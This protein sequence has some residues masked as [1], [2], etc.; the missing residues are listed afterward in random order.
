MPSFGIDN[1]D[2]PQLLEVVLS[3]PSPFSRLFI[4]T[5]TAVFELPLLGPRDDDNL[6]QQRL[7]LL[8]SRVYGNIPFNPNPGITR[9]IASASPSSIHGTDDANELTWAVDRAFADVN[10]QGELILHV[11]AAVQG[12]G[13]L[14]SRFAYQVFVQTSGM[15]IVDSEQNPPNPITVSTT[16]VNFDIKLFPASPNPGG[17]VKFGLLQDGNPISNGNIGIPDSLD[18]PADA[19]SAGISGTMRPSGFPRGKTQLT[20]ACRTTLS[21]F[22]HQ[23]II[24]QT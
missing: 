18:I 20:L 2:N 16:P 11:D 19:I 13:G 22:L 21:V 14:F 4:L 6:V 15:Q 9:V 17:I 24:D 12:A 23:I 8:L 1:V 5:G 3:P 7:D 10:P